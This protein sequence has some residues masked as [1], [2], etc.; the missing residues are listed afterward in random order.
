MDRQTVIDIIRFK[1]TVEHGQAGQW[2][3]AI[4][5]ARKRLL[6]DLDM[7]ERKGRLTG[8]TAYMAVVGLV[9]TYSGQF[10]TNMYRVADSLHQLDWLAGVL[11]AAEEA[12]EEEYSPEF[13]KE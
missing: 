4:E 1:A 3:D 6:F 7:L 2:V 13:R 8:F 10:S 11:L 12:F 9:G 5:K